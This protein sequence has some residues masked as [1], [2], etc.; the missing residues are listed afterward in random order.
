MR[1]IMTPNIC[2]IK[3]AKHTQA[4]MKHEVHFVKYNL[5]TNKFK[6]HN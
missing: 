6:C 4:R 2:R 1:K 3:D 5:E